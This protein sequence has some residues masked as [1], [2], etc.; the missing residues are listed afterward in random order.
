ME[1]TPVTSYLATGAFC[2]KAPLSSDIRFSRATLTT[3]GSPPS[4][5]RS[6]FL[7]EYV[8]NYFADEARQ[9]AGALFVPLGSTVSQVLEWVVHEGVIDSEQIL[10]GFPH[11]SGQ[12]NERISYLLG[13]KDRSKLS[14]KTNPKI[15][16]EAGERIRI[17]IASLSPL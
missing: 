3:T 14:S 1:S 8:R 2:C 13:R 17:K 11:P 15:L 7:K 12:N 6:S 5:L 10:S 9:L 4:V 16:D